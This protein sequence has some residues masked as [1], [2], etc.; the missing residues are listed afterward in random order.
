MR[1]RTRCSFFLRKG[2]S[3]RRLLQSPILLAVAPAGAVT[4]SVKELLEVVSLKPGILL[5][6]VLL[7][8]LALSYIVAVLV[9][10]F[11]QKTEPALPEQ[12]MSADR[13]DTIHSASKQVKRKMLELQKQ[14]MKVQK[15]SEKGLTDSEKKRLL[16]RPAWTTVTSTTSLKGKRLIVGF[17]NRGCSYRRRHAPGCFV[18]GFNANIVQ[19]LS[20]TKRESLTTGR[21]GG[22]RKAPKRGRHVALSSSCSWF[23]WRSS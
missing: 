11:L 9:L 4:V 7:A 10:K 16:S 13:Q 5:W 15:S 2:S 14:F 23:C 3:M 18:C 19:S 22:M 21:A 20:P 12:I 8:T 17:R 6:S 1:P